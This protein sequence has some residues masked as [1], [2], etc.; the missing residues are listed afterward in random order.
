MVYVRSMYIGP[1]IVSYIQVYVLENSRLKL[2]L[3]IIGVV[4]VYVRVMYI[5]VCVTYRCMYSRI[6]V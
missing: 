2:E 4:R 3:T 6:A 1:T 5:Q